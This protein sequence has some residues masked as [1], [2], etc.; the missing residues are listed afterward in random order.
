M[1]PDELRT[2]EDEILALRRRSDELAARLE[3]L[4]DEADMG[5]A[6]P[7]ESGREPN[8]ADHSEP[9]A[10]RSSEDSEVAG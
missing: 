4:R 5:A 2:I 8:S 7:A 3:K 6:E 9:P 1:D 10:R